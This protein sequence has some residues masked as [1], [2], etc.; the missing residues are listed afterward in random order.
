MKKLFILTMMIAFASIY[1][2]ICAQG[3]LQ[4]AWTPAN[5]S[6]NT[7]NM[8]RDAAVYNGKIYVV[9]NNAASSAINVID[10]T[11]GVE[12]PAEQFLSANFTGFSIA[13]DNA[14]NLVVPK[15][16]GGAGNWD[17]NKVNIGSRTVGTMSAFNASS[18]RVDFISIHGNIESTTVPAYVTGASTTTNNNILA[19]EVLGGVRTATSVLAFDRGYFASGADIKWID[20]THFLLTQQSK[21]PL[22]MTVDFAATPYITKVDNIA[23]ASPTTFGGGVAFSLGGIPYLVIPYGANAG[24]GSVAIFDITDITAPV[25][26]G[27]TTSALGTT[28]NAAAHV[29]VSATQTA[30]NEVTVYVF[31]PN[32]GAVA[33][34]ADAVSTPVPS[35]APGTFEATSLDVSLTSATTGAV[36]TYTLDGSTPTAASTPYTAGT[37]ITLPQGTTTIK[38]LAT[39][40]GLFPN[41][42]EA[43]YT[44]TE[45]EVKDCS[46]FKNSDPSLTAASSYSFEQDGSLK[47]ITDLAN[48]TVRRALLHDGKYYV[49]AVDDQKAPKLLVIDPE[50]GSLIKEMSTDGIVTT[51][52]S[53]KSYPYVLSDIAFTA[54]GVLIGANSTVVGKSANAY[55]T[56]D[57]IVYKW[58][59]TPTI[60][61]EDATPQILVTLPTNVDNSILYAGN[62]NSNLVA[63]NIAVSGCSD[64]FTLCFDSHPGNDWTTVYNVRYVSW[65]VQNGAI[66]SDASKYNDTG[67]DITT[68]GEDVKM[69]LSPLGSD[70]YILDGNKILPKEMQFSW[71]TTTA[72]FSPDFTGD[73]P[74]ES[75]GATYFKYGNVIY[76]SVP[77][78]EKQADNTYSYSSCLFDITGGL[79]NAVKV[80][81]TDAVITNQPAISY[82]TSPVIIDNGNMNIYL[83]VGNQLVKYKQHVA[84][85]AI[86][87]TY[88]IPNTGSQRGWSS[89]TD[90]FNDINTTGISDNVT[91]LITSDITQDVNLGLVN[92]TDYSITIKPDVG[93]TPTIT[94]THTADDNAGPTGAFILGC[95]SGLNWSDIAPAKNITIDGLTIKTATAANSANFPIVIIDACENIDIKNCV[96]NHQMAG[97]SYAIYLRVNTARTE[98]NV[99]KRMPKNV[100]IENNEIS[101]Q[102]SGGQAIAVYADAQPAAP[103]TGIVIKNNI[104]KAGTRGLFLNEIS[105]IEISGNEFHVV[106]P[107][108]GLLSFAIMGNTRMDGDILI[109][110]NKFVELKSANTTAGNYGM[111]GIL[112]S[113]G[114]TWYIDNNYFTGFDITAAANTSMMQAIRVGSPCVIRHNTFY[115]NALTNKPAGYGATPADADPAYCAINIAAGSPVIQNNLFVG[116][117]DAFPNFFI[118]GDY[119]TTAENNI[120]CLPENAANAKIASGTAP[121]D[122]N[123]IDKV[124]FADAA[125]GNLDLTGISN[126]DYHLGVPP[127]ADVTT[128]IHGKTRF[129]NLTYAGAFEGDAFAFPPMEAGDYYVPN[130]PGNGA[131]Y[132]ATLKDAF[133]AINKR[134]IAGNIRLLVNGDITSPDNVGLV[135]NTD[136]S[137]TIQP[138]GSATHTITFTNTA[139]NA[140][141]S[142]TFIIG[143]GSGLSW[144]DITPAKNITIDGLTIKTATT[145]LAGGSPIVL[146]DDCENIDIKNCLI[147]HQPSGGYGIQLRGVADRTEANIQKVMPKNLTIENSEIS[148]VSANGTIGF[149]ATGTLLSSATGIVFKN[150]IIRGTNRGVYVNYIDGIEISGNEFHLTSST[151]MPSSGAVV[152][153]A[154]ITGNVNIENNRFTD[155]TSANTY[156]GD[157]GVKG[158]FTIAATPAVWNIINN[159]FAGFNQRVST[160]NPSMIQAIRVNTSSTANILHNTFYLNQLSNALM[161]NPATPVTPTTESYSAIVYVAGNYVVKNNLFV[162]AEDRF[163]NF[164]I[165][166]NPLTITADDNNIFCLPA[167]AVN[168]K[169]SS[170]TIPEDLRMIDQVTFADA[171]AGNLDIAGA[172]NTDK[173][174]AVPPLAEVPYDIYGTLR[175]T[176]FTY[177]GAFEGDPF[178]FTDLP[179]V[180]SENVTVVCTDGQISIKSNNP[181]Q[182][183]KLFDLQGRM[184]TLKQVGS[185]NEYSMPAPGKGIYVVETTTE[186]ARS[187][188]KIMVR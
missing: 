164:F 172:S 125:S 32:N 171:A 160:N 166:G 143:C 47:T 108:T 56:G 57:F 180:A 113:G 185:V 181:I 80:G 159:Y 25:Q 10:G 124:E 72:T 29:A 84:E 13:A 99:T 112:A 48:L 61:L 59:A 92:N 137:I 90:A 122:P 22:I 157:Y 179:A 140:G 63:N 91:L 34:K 87:G 155:I 120:F 119:P 54:D 28:T 151:G 33:Y 58:E 141:P 170:G 46:D 100:T 123:M 153:N 66:V 18:T 130:D 2:N 27:S 127:L 174:L 71:T 163:P 147:Q 183:V 23:I 136:Y 55:Q 24:F 115:M 150:N 132:F 173:N 96:I 65:Q 148:S 86:Q 6:W 106:Q 105:G 81:E 49:L 138:D 142:G 89:L 37:P 19:W 12:I 129:A 73:I 4:Q 35:P 21:T 83:L 144:T 43:T 178:I 152:T 53:G 97:A 114:G 31:S 44:V 168:A 74:V 69:S 186:S 8:S 42:S 50:T 3:T 107:N 52:Y 128:D 167:N 101:I 156:A 175:Y 60:A 131:E 39:A 75:T 20:D 182:T 146:I 158:I 94:F 117:E 118:R 14:G 76:M 134:T 121:T 110:G 126:T 78:C 45:P 133:D 162:S 5:Y 26:I 16:T 145:A 30:D 36:I 51:G 11:T 187:I 154:G 135:N 68:L 139:D 169:I 161:N 40:D 104:L 165:S 98:A 41:I 77:K 70:R 93:L 116:A 149:S 88:Y 184:I 102:H 9:Y 177:A 176:D 62:N 15:N 38:M 109:A 64:N 82:M 7:G 67:F 17:L 85:D 103:A 188:N 1:A 111:R 79:A 95:G